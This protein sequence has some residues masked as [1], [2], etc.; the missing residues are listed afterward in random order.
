MY[1]CRDCKKFMQP[2]WIADEELGICGED[3]FGHN[4]ASDRNEVAC[5][6]YKEREECEILR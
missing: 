3:M 1:L 2:S 5:E 6:Y 4:E